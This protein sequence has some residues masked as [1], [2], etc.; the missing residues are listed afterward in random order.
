M[1]DKSRVTRHYVTMLVAVTVSSCL[2][3]Y[4]WCRHYSGG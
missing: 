4:R 1:P 2:L 3:S